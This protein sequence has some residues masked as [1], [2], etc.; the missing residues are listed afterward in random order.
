[1]PMSEP[2]VMARIPRRRKPGIFASVAVILGV[3][4]FAGACIG[5]AIAGILAPIKLLGLL[6]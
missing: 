5:V 2:E 4:F 6:F 1:M 3:I